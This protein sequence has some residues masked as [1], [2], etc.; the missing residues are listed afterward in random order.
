MQQIISIGGGGFAHPES[1]L[2][3]ERYI[4]GLTNKTNPKVCL[5]PQA[6][7]ESRE[8]I[9]SFY[10]AFTQLA[11]LPSWISLFGKV[12]AQWREQL[13]AQDVIYVG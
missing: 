11:A 5:L 10:E 12:K 9:V 1:K 3:L 8:V 7:N 6:S 4:L 2:K 13:L